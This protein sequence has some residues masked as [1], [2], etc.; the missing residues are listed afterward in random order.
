[1]CWV[2]LISSTK[3]KRGTTLWHCRTQCEEANLHTLNLKQQ[4]RSS[5][6]F[7][8]ACYLYVWVDHIYSNH[9]VNVVL[10]VTVHSLFSLPGKIQPDSKF[11]EVNRETQHHRQDRVNPV[12][13]QEAL[14]KRKS[15]PVCC[16]EYLFSVLEF[17]D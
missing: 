5:D 12:P 6:T 9:S 4:C 10:P 8:S 16:L 3:R 1:M 7:G 2:C 13:G 17:T 11:T 14:R 15:H